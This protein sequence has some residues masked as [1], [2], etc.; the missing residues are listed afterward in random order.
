MFKELEPGLGPVAYANHIRQL[1][2]NGG[3]RRQDSQV[4]LSSQLSRASSRKRRNVSGQSLQEE[5][6]GQ[7]DDDYGQDDEQTIQNIN[8]DE[9]IPQ[10]VELTIISYPGVETAPILPQAEAPR[11]QYK[12]ASVGTPPPAELTITA[13]PGIETAPVLPQAEALRPQYVDVGVGTPQPADMTLSLYSGPETAPVAP[14]AQSPR[15]AY[16]D[17][18]VGTPQ[19][20]KTT[21]L[22]LVA[23]R[24]PTVPG[25]LKFLLFMMFTCYI[26]SFAGLVDERHTWLAAN[27]L[28]RQRVAAWGMD[29][30][31]GLLDPL[32]FSLE[33]WLGVDNIM[34]G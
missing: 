28:S 16:K 27:E 18:G 22:E 3:L 4:S 33:N 9:P 2:S 1:M 13:Y 31:G 10:P 30:N 21:T 11:R 32:F 25:W 29:N 34:L 20:V 26:Y 8:T 5:V 17:V 12:D 19:T 15:P 24:K 14:Q 7:D 6:E 23:P